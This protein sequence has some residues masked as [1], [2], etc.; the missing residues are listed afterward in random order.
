MKRI[1][2]AAVLLGVASMAAGCYI[3]VDG[4]LYSDGYGDVTID[5]TFDGLQCDQAGV[6]RIRIALEGR[7][8]GD[9]FYDTVRCAG[10]RDGVVVYDMFA[11]EYDLYVDGL[12]RDGSVLYASNRPT[13]VR[14]RDNASNFASV[15]L[16][17]AAADL[18]LTWSFPG[19]TQ[20]SEVAVVAVT[21]RDPDGFIYD[22][23]RYPCGLGRVEYGGVLPG[24][25]SVEMR[26]FDASD[27]LVFR[28]R[29]SVF[30]VVDQSF[31]EYSF[32]LND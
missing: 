3:D 29:E 23:S 9:A 32:V 30:R 22:D 18:A 6:D 11:D 5:Y 10:F 25:W 2:P 1:I 14:V 15:N 20:C 31:N 17:Y 13:F 7:T 27:G 16:G 8:F 21:L 19:N 28:L 4:D 24:Q 12:A 26:A